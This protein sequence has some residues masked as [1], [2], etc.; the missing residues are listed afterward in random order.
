MAIVVPAQRVGLAPVR[1]V[2]SD[3]NLTL[4]ANTQAWADVDTGGTAAA[5][6]LDVVISGVTAGQW[7]DLEVN[8]HLASAAAVCLLDV[9]TVVSG[10]PVNQFGSTEIGVSGWVVN[11]SIGVDLVGR[12]SYQLQAGDI[13]G[14]SVR[15]RLRYK[16]VHATV[17]RVLDGTGGNRI[18]LEGRGPFGSA[19]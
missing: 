13:E 4:V 15:L 16:N 17:A 7:V 3:A 10:S 6:P 5:R 2:K 8:A 11:A 18:V 1:V 12:M 9:F 14:G 19:A